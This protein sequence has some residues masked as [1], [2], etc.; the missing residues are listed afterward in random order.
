[1]PFVVTGVRAALADKRP[2]AAERW[3]ERVRGLLADWPDLA[4]PALDHADG[5]VR[6]AAGSIVAART[7][8]ESAVEGW[9]R[10][11]RIW[12]STWARVDLATCL[13]RSNR[14]ADA[15]RLL[16]QVH[17]TAERLG[18]EPIRARVDELS[19]LSRSRGGEVEPW[20]PLSAREFEVAQKIAEG[21]TNAQ[22]GEELFVSPKTVSAHVEHILAKLGVSRRAEIATWVASVRTP[23]AVS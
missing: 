10:K 15:I 21:L 12:E 19:R 22:I 14:Y 1:V 4:R 17:A 20:H 5:L 2:E 8:L 13:V 18:S 6:L 16:D 23:V 7:A 3:L 11:D 9:D